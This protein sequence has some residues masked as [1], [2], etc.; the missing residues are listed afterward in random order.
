MTASTGSENWISN[1]KGQGDITSMIKVV[2]ATIYD[3]DNKRLPQKLSKGTPVTYIDNQSKEYSKVAIRVG[4]DIFFTRIDNLIKPKTLGAVNL[5]PQAFGLGAPL[6]LTSYVS[7]LKKSIKNRNNIKGELQEYLLDLVDYV[8]SGGGGLVGF[9]FNELPMASIRNDF[10]EVLG[11]IFCLRN[12][13]I[14]LNLGVNASSTIS[15]PASGTEPLLDYFIN[16]PTKQIK[17]S[18]KAKGTSNTLKMSAL[19]PA[20]LNDSKLSIKHANSLEFR[21]MSTIN[22]NS[23]NMGAIECAL[24]IGAISPQAAGSVRGL[25][26]NGT[27]IPNPQLFIDLISNESILRS[28]QKFTLREIAYACEKKVVEFSRKTMVSKKLTEIVKDILDNEIFFV[29]LDIDNGIPRFNIVSTSDR[30]ISN[31]VFRNKNDTGR[32]SDRLGFKL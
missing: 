20:V 4:Q 12:G 27:E 29:K 19:V 1:W 18:A 14:N 5:K 16:T 10:G 7:T 2:D 22:S 28:K 25:R 26:G 24:L 32:A 9:K 15:F 21:L 11:P 31:L 3:K 13:L 30:T 23:I 17:V 6:S 8:F